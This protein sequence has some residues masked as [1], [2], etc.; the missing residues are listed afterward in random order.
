MLTWFKIFKNIQ[1]GTKSLQSLVEKGLMEVSK[2]E[3]TFQTNLIRQTLRPHLSWHVTL[4]SKPTLF[5]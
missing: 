2:N 4:K 3:H 1:Y 5:C